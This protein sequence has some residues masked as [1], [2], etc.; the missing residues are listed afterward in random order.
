[1]PPQKPQRTSYLATLEDARPEV[2]KLVK[3]INLA[4]TRL[5]IKNVVLGITDPQSGE[6][7]VLASR[8]ALVDQNMRV[9]VAAKFGFEDGDDTG[10]PS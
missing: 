10:W 3:S 1:M 7:Y 5:G 4:V 8:P 2:K 9:A 6:T